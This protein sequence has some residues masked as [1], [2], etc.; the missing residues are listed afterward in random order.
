MK[1]ILERPTREGWYFVMFAGW[2]CHHVWLA[3][4]VDGILVWDDIDDP[5]PAIATYNTEPDA[6]PLYYA[7]P[8]PEPKIPTAFPE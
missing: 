6:T 8:I 5:S 1:Y 4:R 3:K 7:G 2:N